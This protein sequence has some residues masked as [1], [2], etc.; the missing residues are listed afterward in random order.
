MKYADRM[1]LD[2]LAR[3]YVL[4]TLRGAARRR[5][6]GLLQFDLTLRQSVREWEE[7]LVP[8]A[9][10][11]PPVTPPDR[12]LRALNQ[13]LGI[14]A[15]DAEPPQT[16]NPRLWPAIAATFALLAIVLGMALIQREPQPLEPAYVSIIAD[17]EA[18]PVWFLQ[19]YPEQHELRVRAVG[20]ADAP[21]S[22]D[23]ELWMLPDDKSA[24]VSLGLL[25]AR[26][27]ARFV[28]SESQLAVLRASSTLA[29]S[30]E[31]AGGSPTGAP[32]GPVV[33]TAPVVRT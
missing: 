33:Y 7:R 28:L 18:Q 14:A 6:E 4:G 30:L 11:L 26:G 19:T 12:I 13:R 27:T 21:G 3:E 31:P 20:E 25:P 8:L 17:A 23:Y 9:L 15:R 32:T 1:M 29:V 22:Q 16:R 2:R 5:F 10:T 24:P